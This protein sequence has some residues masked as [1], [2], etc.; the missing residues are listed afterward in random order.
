MPK[1]KLGGLNMRLSKFSI[2]CASALLALALPLCASSMSISV[3]SNL[4]NATGDVEVDGVYV[5]SNS[6]YDINVYG[7]KA[8]STALSNAFVKNGSTINTATDFGFDSQ[9][10]YVNA[11]ERI[12]AVGASASSDNSS[13]G[14]FI[15][16]AVGLGVRNGFT[17]SL[18]TEGTSS[19]DPRVTYNVNK[20]Q[21]NGQLAIGANAHSYKYT[22]TTTPATC[23]YSSTAAKVAGSDEYYK[24]K[25][26]INGAY[27]YTGKFN[28]GK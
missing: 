15:N 6:A 10:G 11:T 17:T 25:Q 1:T 28:I 18:K 26:Q 27:N 14:E 21:G 2:T 19:S 4:D 7:V 20:A 24:Y 23:P 13:Q 3:N 5:S 16:A 9:R 12:G 8:S 22:D